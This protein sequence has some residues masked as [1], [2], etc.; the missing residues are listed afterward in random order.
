LIHLDILFESKIIYFEN[1]KVF[2]EL[3]EENIEFL[4]E[5]YLYHYKKLIEIYLEK[6]D[7]KEF[8]DDYVI[9]EN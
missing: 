5:K 7:A 3:T 8:L 6:K 4:K 1:H 9:E 2:L